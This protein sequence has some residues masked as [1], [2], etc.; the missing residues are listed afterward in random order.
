[1]FRTKNL[2]SDCSPPWRYFSGRSRRAAMSNARLLGGMLLF[3]T[4][5]GSAASAQITPPHDV[6][7]QPMKVTLVLED[8]RIRFTSG[9]QAR[10]GR[11]DIAGLD[12]PPVFDSGLSTASTLDWP[13]VDDQNRPVS[14]GVYEYTL[15][16]KAGHTERIR[17][18]QL[19]VERTSTVYRVSS[20]RE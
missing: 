2:P 8:Q 17:R 19:T 13:L 14:D 11:L 5:S 10:D 6:Q 1:A 20:T 12:A 18:G 3:L 7:D 4:F 9:G 15:T 16:I